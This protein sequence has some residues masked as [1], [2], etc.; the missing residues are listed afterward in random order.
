MQNIRAMLDK[1]EVLPVSPSMLPKLL[2]HLSDVDGNFDEVVRIISLEQS[3]TAKLL[4]ICNSAFFGLDE[5][6]SSVTDAVNRVGYQ[7]IYL[8]TAM[9]NG[10][11]C[12]PQVSFGGLN[13]ATLWK[14]SVATALNSKFAAE[15]AGL[16]TNLLFTAGLMHDIGKVIVAQ[17]VSVKNGHD[18][19]QPTNNDSLESELLLFGG[20]H[21]IVGAT[22]L[23]KWQLP[24]P[25]IA[26]IRYH[27]DPQNA[28]DHQKIAAAVTIGDCLAHGADRPE[29][30]RSPA[31]IA[32]LEI[33]RLDS[34]HLKRWNRQFTESGDLIA[35]MS[36]LPL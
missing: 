28:G 32:A 20:N 1:V 22:L 26:C 25:L 15:S 24:P 31:F 30:T 3:L 17:T 23:E 19:H 5:P 7:S 18:F 4:Q 27:H 6:V 10:S 16:D 29:S 33:L 34:S 36:K 12:F 11:N 35:G 13:T 8:L 21:A 14:H 9:I 2:P